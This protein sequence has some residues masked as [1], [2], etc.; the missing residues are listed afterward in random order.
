MSAITELSSGWPSGVIGKR[1]FSGAAASLIQFASGQ[2][3]LEAVEGAFGGDIDYA[4]LVK[5][6]GPAP[7]QSA[8]RRYSPAECTGISMRSVEGNPNPNH[9]STS[10]VE[11]QNLN[12]RMGNRRVTRL[13]NAFSKKGDEP[14]AH[15]VDLLHALQ[16]RAHSSD[17]E[18]DACDGGKRHPE[19]LGDGR[20]GEGA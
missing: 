15:D 10:Y 19:A 4:M 7:E 18:D 2:F 13:T 11:R 12:I 16:F 8:A 6:Y 14:R 5:H 9:I 1:T 20:H 3:G 17:V